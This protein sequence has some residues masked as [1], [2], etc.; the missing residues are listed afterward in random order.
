MGESGPLTHLA[1]STVVGLVSDTHLPRFGRRLPRALVEGF[2]AAG[3]SAVFHLGDHTAGFVV[4]LLSEIPGVGNGA[5]E[6]VAGNND[7]PELIERFGLARVVIVDGLRV[8]LTHGH[9]GIE[10]STAERALMTFGPLPSDVVEVVTFGHSHVPIVERRGSVLLVNP[11][12][13]TD[14]RRQ[15]AFSF[16]LLRV[17]GGQATAEIVQFSSRETGRP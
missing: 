9:L 17:E 14:R 2:E 3:V 13:P 11:G 8:G 4:D 16:G 15:P 10:R 1:R 7:P 5:V 6:P 12:S